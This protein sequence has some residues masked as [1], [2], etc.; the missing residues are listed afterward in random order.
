MCPDNLMVLSMG[1]E[2]YPGEI[3]SEPSVKMKADTK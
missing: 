2:G 3:L 1:E